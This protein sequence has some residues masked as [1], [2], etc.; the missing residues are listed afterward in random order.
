ML[1]LNSK[2]SAWTLIEIN[3]LSFDSPTI[4]KCSASPPYLCLS[5]SVQS[6]SLWM[7]QLTQL[8]SWFQSTDHFAAKPSCSNFPDLF[9]LINGSCG[10]LGG[11][12]AKPKLHT[13]S[14]ICTKLEEDGPWDWLLGYPLDT[15][16]NSQFKNNIPVHYHSECPSTNAFKLARDRC[17]WDKQHSSNSS[18]CY[19]IDSVWM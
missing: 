17:L 10:A 14:S 8:T 3:C 16:H 9:L 18:D 5:P 7:H 2:L 11:L 19:I 13:L 1:N 4:F 15:G 12:R 6:N